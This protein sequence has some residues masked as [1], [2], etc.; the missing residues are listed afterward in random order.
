M[1]S[2]LHIYFLI[3]QLQICDTCSSLQPV[4]VSDIFSFLQLCYRNKYSEIFEHFDYYL[5]MSNL[6]IYTNI[7]LGNIKMELV[8]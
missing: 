4:D 1:I 2:F 6:K 5:L 7:M 8:Y 3:R